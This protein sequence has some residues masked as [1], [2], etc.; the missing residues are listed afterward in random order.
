[1]NDMSLALQVMTKMETPGGV[2]EPLS[3]DNKKD[4][5]GSTSLI[6]YVPV[7]NEISGSFP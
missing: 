5:H 6:G 1:M 3:A 4:L 7:N 2:P